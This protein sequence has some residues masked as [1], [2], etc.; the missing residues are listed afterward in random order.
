MVMF[1]IRSADSGHPSCSPGNF[2]LYLSKSSSSAADHDIC[3][4]SK[5]LGCTG[6]SSKSSS[7]RKPFLSSSYSPLGL[8]SSKV[9]VGISR[10]I[11]SLNSNWLLKL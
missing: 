8:V 5:V 7:N 10:R 2:A 4:S 3:V 1:V 6:D 9:G 11:A